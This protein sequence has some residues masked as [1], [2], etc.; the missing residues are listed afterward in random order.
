MEN[1]SHHAHI[2]VCCAVCVC[3]AR[4]HVSFIYRRFLASV[5]PH[6]VA[7]LQILPLGNLSAFP[8][9]VLDPKPFLS[10]HFYLE[11]W[12]SL[13]LEFGHSGRM[14]TAFLLQMRHCHVDVLKYCI[15]FPRYQ[16]AWFPFSVE[17]TDA[18]HP[19]VP[20][21]W[22]TLDAVEHR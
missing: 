16:S 19:V 20:Q 3:G 17:C 22:L 12:F 7:V 10:K 9:E 1:C 13:W 21:L 8:A 18:S 2:H 11:P 4:A 15:T 5:L 6:S 14:W